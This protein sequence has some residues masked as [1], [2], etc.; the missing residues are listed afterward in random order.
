MIR[1]PLSGTYF[2]TTCVQ[3]L[4]TY[5]VA[6]CAQELI[7]YY[8]TPCAQELITYYVTTCAQELITCQL[9][10]QLWNQFIG[11][12]SAAQTYKLATKGPVTE[13]LPLL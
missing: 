11:M 1:K 8:V 3:E 4:I 12:C 5:Y 10:C 2:V 6:T 13:K 7:T 9:V